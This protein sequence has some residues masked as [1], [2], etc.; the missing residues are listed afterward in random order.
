MNL[1]YHIQDSFRH[2]TVSVIIP[3][4]NRKK[5]LPKAIES[6]FKQTYSDYE[7]IVIDDASTDGTAEWVAFAYPDITCVHLTENRGSA[8]ARNEGLKIAQGTYIAYLDSDDQWLP[9]YLD[10][11]VKALEENPNDVLTVCDYT[12]IC[13]DFRQ[14]VQSAP[15]AEYSNFIQYFLLDN[16][17]DTMSIVVLRHSALR[18]AGLMNERLKVCHDRE[19]YLRLV[20]FGGIV[21]TP[22]QLVLRFMHSDNLVGNHRAWGQDALLFVDLFFSDKARSQAYR[23]VQYQA[24]GAWALTIAKVALAKY[25][26]QYACT[27]Y[28]RAFFFFCLHRQYNREVVDG[29]RKSL[30]AFIKQSL[31][32]REVSMPRR[33]ARKFMMLFR[34]KNRLPSREHG[35]QPTTPTNIVFFI[36]NRCNL[37]CRHCFYWK[38]LNDRTDEMNL[39]QIKV[40]ASSLRHAAYI[41]LTGGEPFLRDDLEEI[42]QILLTSTPSHCLQFTTNGFLP[43][44]VD[45]VIRKIVTQWPFNSIDVQISL[46]GLAATHD[47]IRGVDGAFNRTVETIEKL[48]ELR[49]TH[50]NLT[51]YLSTVIMK[52]NYN[53]I[54][55]LIK[56]T[57]RF[58]V[59]HGFAFV[60]GEYST[61]NLAPQISSGFDLQKEQDDIVSE[62]H[63]EKLL[64]KIFM[65]NR[66]LDFSFLSELQQ[67]KLM[68]ALEILRAQKRII[69][70]FAGRIDGVVYPDGNV[71]LCEHTKPIGNL[72]DTSYDFYALWHSEQA[73]S[74]RA[75]IR[76]CECIHGCNL[77][78][79]L[80]AC[81]QT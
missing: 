68:T 40:F 35:F 13:N 58:R 80:V 31:Q 2:P 74:M 70:C 8:G 63:L 81:S 65:L 12:L 77:I 1:R 14:Q 9:N 32:S 28:A 79:S 49:R 16:F 18:K 61:F 30:G 6:V 38:Q 41:T 27:M 44:R 76:Q 34:D 64:Q 73:N 23:H 45:Q 60:R 37:R 53:E 19:L 43:D 20:E 29:L 62:E 10:M 55:R 11:Q 50:S 56:Y 26:Y 5:F 25:D 71:A 57:Q 69:P 17:I 15:K 59:P 54:E 47:R 3:T 67:K 48:S 52:A 22:H 36:T 66:T 51:L 39:E 75:R 21:H 24:Y 78:S 7:I 46:D 4:F 72:K 42:C 33:I